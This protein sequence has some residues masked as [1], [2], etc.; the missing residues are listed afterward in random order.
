V[1]M[2]NNKTVPGGTE[3]K[4][5]I[6]TDSLQNN[7]TL[8]KER[9]KDCPDVIERSL[10]LK[11]NKEGHIFFLK[12]MVDYNLLQGDFIK[13][14]T[15]L[16]FN[17]LIDKKSF[18]ALPVNN[19]G[20]YEEV[21]VVV[22]QILNG[23]A[24]LLCDGI[25]FAVG[26]GLDGY[27]KRAIEE[28]QTEK[29]LKGPHDGFIEELD[30]NIA[31]LRRKIKNSNLKFKM[32]KQGA[33]TN[34]FTA[35]AYI[36]GIANEELLTKLYD[37]VKAIN[38]DGLM[39]M[40]YIEQSIVDFPNSPFPQYLTT[41]RPDKA[42]SA[43]LE[44]KLVILLEGTPVVAIAPVTFFSFFQSPDDYSH[45]WIAGTF[46]RLLRYIGM[47][48]AI[49]LPAIYIAVTSFHFYM[50]PID[51]LITLGESRARVPFSPIIETL[52][53]EITIELIRE[54]AAR[55]PTYVGT[56]IGVVG[57]LVIGQA[58]VEAGIVSNVLIIIVAVT[59]I[60]S[61]VIPNEA[62]G[63][64][65]RTIRFSMSM[66]AAIFGIIGI[67]VVTA[68]LVAHQLTLESLG[69]PYYQP[70]IPFKVNGL[71]DTFARLPLKLHKKRPGTTKP[72]DSQRGKDNE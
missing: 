72:K 14:I 1:P 65:I 28:P 26:T 32:I 12:A 55:L 11:G 37:K 33:A 17:A 58:A 19:I 41:E 16:D 45:G 57:G 9:L 30:T 42:M 20:F 8:I 52:V 38:I 69:Q 23:N 67:V 31:I 63:L 36:E 2:E 50:V 6:L 29:V 40:G 44:G 46:L 51:L 62:M 71:K 61:Y 47:I 7:L 35:I 66:A 21:D 34:Q 56:T 10:P 15:L 54:A 25:N 68:L 49:F 24:V 4:K 59:A 18:E 48:I 60:A 3:V 22:G 64:A 13:P 27:A 39:S 43:L 70:V 53:L 5:T